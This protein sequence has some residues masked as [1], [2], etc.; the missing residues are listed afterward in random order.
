MAKGCS[1]SL[2][3]SYYTCLFG[4]NSMLYSKPVIIF[5]YAINNPFKTVFPEGK[6]IKVMPIPASGVLSILSGSV[7]VEPNLLLLVSQLNC[8][9]QTT[10]CTHFIVLAVWNR[11]AVAPLAQAAALGQMK[12][13]F[14]QILSPHDSHSASSTVCLI[15][16]VQGCRRHTG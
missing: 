8:H 3:C 13:L 12:G 1:R 5:L 6:E 14:P 9:S 7:V 11:T 4:T 10:R 16:K 15:L 2:H